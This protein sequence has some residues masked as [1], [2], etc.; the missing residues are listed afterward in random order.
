MKM[1]R[2]Y[3]S[4]IRLVLLMATVSFQNMAFGKNV[5]LSPNKDYATAVKQADL[6]SQKGDYSKTIDL[7]WKHIDSLDRKA[8]IL[9]ALAHEKRNEANNMMKVATVLVSK[10]S[11]D[12]EA[13]YLLGSAYLLNKKSTEALEALKTSLEINPK[14]QPAYEK[15]AQMYEQ[16]QN[17]YELRI[18]YQD[19]IDKIGKMPQFLNKLCEI[20]TIRD[21]QEDQAL[22]YCK[23]AIAKDPKTAENRVYLGIIQKNSGNEEEAK[24]TLRLAADSY[25]KSEFAQYTYSNLMDD[26]KNYI[27]GAKYYQKCTEADRSSARCWVGYARMTF[28]IHKYEPA[29]EAFKKACSLDRKNAVAFRKASNALKN[30]KD[31]EWVKQYEAASE[32]CSG[33]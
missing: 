26:Q 22:F 27:E 25:S 6:A 20:N 31:S 3:K 21:Y 24:K 16:K 33:Y 19:M 13:H 5:D 17:S 32:S 15:L 9:L 4:L 29:L 1:L 2:V 28:E 18:L 12:H 7:L 14:Y 11:K 30:M 10:N 23:Q 8:L